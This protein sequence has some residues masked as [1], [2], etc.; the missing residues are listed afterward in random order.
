MDGV[1]S[2]NTF[3]TTIPDKATVQSSDWQD[4][5]LIDMPSGIS[6]MEA[7][8]TGFVFVGLYARPLP[9]GKKNVSKMSELEMKLNEVLASAKSTD[10]VITRND[11]HSTFDVDIDWHCNVVELILKVF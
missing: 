2:D 9:S 8:G 7:F 1:I 10:Y 11:A 5:V 6:D 4:M 3:F